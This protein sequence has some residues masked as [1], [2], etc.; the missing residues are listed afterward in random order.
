MAIDRNVTININDISPSANTAYV[1][2]G[3]E[4]K[5]Y[6]KAQINEL[7]EDLKEGTLGSISPSQTLEELNALED[8]N[9]YAAEAGTYAFG[10]T[11]PNGWQYRFNKVGNIWKVLTKVEIPNIN[12]SNKVIE[13]DTNAVEGGA[14]YTALEP[15]KQMIDSVEVPTEGSNQLT[16]TENTSNTSV[17]TVHGYSFPIGIVSL[18]FNKVTIPFAQSTASP[19]TQLEIRLFENSPSGN[20]VVKKR[21]SFTAGETV[22]TSVTAVF[23]T[24]ITN[25]NKLWCQV[26]VNNPFAVKRVSPATKFTANNGYLAPSAT[27]VN[28]LDGTTFSIA[29]SHVDVLLI[30]NSVINSFSEINFTNYGKS[31]IVEVIEEQG[32]VHKNK[33][34]L[35]WN[36]VGHS[37]WAQDGVEY[38]YPKIIAKGIQTLIQNKIEF[39]GY[40]RYCYSS[41]SLGAT[42]ESGDINSITN[43]FNTWTDSSK[44]F[45]TLDTI[46]NDFKRDIP[47]GTIDDYINNTG[48]LTYYGA[49]R[50]F[51][52]KV[53]SLTIE[54]N[55]N[56]VIVANAMNR[57]NGGYTSTSTNTV[58]ATL[59]SYEQALMNVAQINGWHFIDQR[60]FS[61]IYDDNLNITTKRNTEGGVTD[62]LHPND[63]G[64]SLCYRIWLDEFK[65]LFL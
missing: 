45:W 34:D 14:V 25:N 3:K 22:Q 20:L 60:R 21:V 1:D 36:C 30:F 41:R 2:V 19:V 8:G 35:T 32:I 43:Y 18:P 47:V 61:G 56:I 62:G 39:K 49:L 33:I 23:D 4:N 28:N 44:G 58:G 38:I 40:N 51:K 31:K 27:T 63:F 16:T 26:L 17:S 54:G 10:V 29:Q 11:V 15:S 46:T 5:V 50:K 7:V 6:N 52:D 59:Y 13:N 48:A 65:R 57:N 9:Y 42:S 37:I 24:I 53:D 64:Y 55:E 12:K